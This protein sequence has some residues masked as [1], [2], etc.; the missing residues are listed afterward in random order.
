[1]QR[2]LWASFLASPKLQR[3]SHGEA[4]AGLFC[5][6]HFDAVAAVWVLLD[7]CEPSYNTGVHGLSF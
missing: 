7:I 3:S 4:V 6:L 1:M 5:F 2:L